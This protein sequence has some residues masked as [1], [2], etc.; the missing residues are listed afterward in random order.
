MRDV[1]CQGCGTKNSS[2]N[3]FCT[4]CG[5]PLLRNIPLVYAQQTVAAGQPAPPLATRPK[6]RRRVWGALA[7]VP[8]V[9]A[10]GAVAE[11]S[12][13]LG[14]DEGQTRGYAEGYSAGM[15]DG[16]LSAFESLLDDT[17]GI[18]IPSP[19]GV[20]SDIYFDAFPDSNSESTA[21]VPHI[22][23]AALGYIENPVLTEWTWVFLLSDGSTT[24]FTRDFDPG[25]EIDFSRC[26]EQSQ[27]EE[28]ARI[29]GVGQVRYLGVYA[30]VNGVWD[31]KVVPMPR[32]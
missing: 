6:M 7:F 28:M 2:S 30:R 20:V 8:V 4:D 32:G 11:I 13:D 10:I 1:W 17:V 31:R 27:V 23:V 24:S 14:Y 22:C 5:R 15:Q 25:I 9:F 18:S 16:V 29:S 21:P 19:G 26:Y 3:Q 12:G